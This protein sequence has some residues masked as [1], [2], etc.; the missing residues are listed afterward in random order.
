MGPNQGVMQAKPLLLATAL[1]AVPLVGCLASSQTTQA[2]METEPIAKGEDSAIGDRETHVVRSA[3]TWRQLWD[4]HA[5]DA[6]PPAIDFDQ[7]MVL[8]AFMG[9]SPDTCHE[10]QFVNVTED[11]QGVRVDGRWLAIEAGFC[12]Q[13]VTSPFAMASVPAREE[14]VTFAMENATAEAAGESEDEGGEPR[15]SLDVETIARGGDSE[16]AAERHVV[17]RNQSAWTSLWREHAGNDSASPPAVDFGEATVLAVFKGQS[18]DACH[19]ANVTHVEAGGE[20][21]RAHVVYRT[22][23]ESACAMQVTYPFHVVEI[24]RVDGEVTFTVE[25]R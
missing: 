25:E 16:I 2:P 12:A 17:V 1:L 10:V 21:A 23:G 15:G 22:G 13:Q 4:R 3:E 9:S 11:G 5:P 20:D 18:P 7:R 6:E 19:G 24:P 8:A 14:P